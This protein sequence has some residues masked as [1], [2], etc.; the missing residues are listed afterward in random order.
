MK[1]FLGESFIINLQ[2]AIINYPQID[3]PASIWHR[4]LPYQHFTCSRPLSITVL[5]IVDDFN[6]ETGGTIVLPGSHQ[7]AEFPST[8]FALKYKQQISA[9]AGSALVLDSMIY[10]QAGYNRSN[11]VRRAI[12]HIYTLPLIKQQISYP[13][14]LRGLY[15]DDP[16]LNKLLGYDSEPP[17][18]V[19]KYREERLYKKGGHQRTKVGEG[20]MRRINES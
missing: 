12:A 16:V 18:N 15:E 19:L 6:E 4:D 13:Q 17:E 3:N 7:Y 2:N 11:Q 9:K 8:E 20:R 1:F 14:L 5:H 10:H